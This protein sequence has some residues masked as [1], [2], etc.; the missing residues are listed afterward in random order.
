MATTALIHFLF[1]R[2]FGISYQTDPEDV[3]DA[4]HIPSHARPAQKEKD[5][6]TGS[7]ITYIQDSRVN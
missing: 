1:E 6:V 4:L 2:V 7:A 5:E 3:I